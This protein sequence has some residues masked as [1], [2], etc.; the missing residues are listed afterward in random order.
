MQYGIVNYFLEEGKN[1]ENYIKTN[2][3]VPDVITSV[4]GQGR[5]GDQKGSWKEIIF[6]QCF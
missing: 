1:T 3:R 2:S 4:W 5:G 6:E